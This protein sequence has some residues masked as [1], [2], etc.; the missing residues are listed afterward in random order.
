LNAGGEGWTE[1]TLG[2]VANI[3]PRE[4]A[5]SSEAPFVPMD[6]VNIGSRDVYYFEPRGDRGGVRARSG[7][8]LFARITP[9][10]ENGKVAQIQ[11][12]IGLCGGS[13]EFIVIRGTDLIS[14][15]FIY[16][17]CTSIETRST[18]SN[19]MVG[20]TGRQRLSARDLASIRL[21]LPPSTDQ[22]RIVMSIASLDEV[23]LRTQA[24]LAS[25][26]QLR[27]ALLNKEIS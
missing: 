24:A 12:G 13:T 9:C 19:L 4:S 5:L 7:D 18:A 14:S 1:T 16:F 3:N 23:A 26:R 27:S 10:L 6:A 22:T 2:E 17:W 11:D 15:D 8:V 25:T 20:T 21:L